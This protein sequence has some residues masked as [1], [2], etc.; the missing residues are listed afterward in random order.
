MKGEGLGVG[1]AE[2]KS[3]SGPGGP[4]LEV[5]YVGAM[6]AEEPFGLLAK[7]S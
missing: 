3:G 4:P 2:S 5:M 6:A 7:A 1:G